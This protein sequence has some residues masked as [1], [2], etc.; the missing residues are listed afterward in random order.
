M[1]I[2]FQLEDQLEQHL[3]RD[4]GDLSQAAREALLIEAYRRGTLSIGRL[5]ESL[6]IGVLEADDWLAKRGISLNYSF[7][8]FQSDQ[9][10]LRE[11]R[12]PS[13]R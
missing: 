12:P 9:S 8:E 1:T 3:R 2:S 11:I 7:E 13:L 6:G 10:T 4:L 5:A